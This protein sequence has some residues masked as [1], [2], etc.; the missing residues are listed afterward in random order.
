MDATATYWHLSERDFFSGLVSEKNEFIS[1]SKKRNI[2]KNQF[3]FFQ[4]D[5]GDSAFYIEKGE[6]RVF[7]ISPFGK[8]SVVF[9][10]F[11]G[12]IFGLAEV[13]GGN[14]RAC[15]A[16]AMTRCSLYE[17]KRKELEVLLCRHYCLAERVMK[18]MGRRLRYL[19]EQIENLMIC[20]VH[21][22][23]LKL[24]VY[25]GHHELLDPGVWSN[26]VTIPIRLT[27]Q[28]IAEMIGSCQQTVSATLKRLELEGLIRLA[29]KDIILLK[30]LDAL[31]CIVSSPDYS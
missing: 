24:L 17:I 31:N 12:E 14:N 29:G 21:T 9:I 13:I 10:R 16:Q 20:D 11:P 5:P 26:P 19:G 22:R 18:V 27:Q 8:S 7:R 6:I 15:S 30:P 3:V 2:S 28:Q 23:L 25:L 4:D 1:L